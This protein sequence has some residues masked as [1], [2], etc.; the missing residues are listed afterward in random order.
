MSV[1][2]VFCDNAQ[3]FRKRLVV[4]GHKTR[5][6]ILIKCFS[7]LRDEMEHL[8]DEKRCKIC[9]DSPVSMVLQPCRHLVCCH[10]CSYKIKVCPIC[11]AR[12]TKRLKVFTT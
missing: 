12:I 11:R 4:R 10:N 1:V 5:N 9:L 2:L 8:K 3:A 6:K 7:E